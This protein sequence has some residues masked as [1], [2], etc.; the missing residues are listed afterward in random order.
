[1]K[2]VIH[3]PVERERLEKTFLIEVRIAGQRGDESKSF[4][5]PEIA[6]ASTASALS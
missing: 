6:E 4:R 1:M 5:N 2:L 3:P